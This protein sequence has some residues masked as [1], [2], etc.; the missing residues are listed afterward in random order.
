MWKM[1]SIFDS[2]C[3][4]T[5]NSINPRVSPWIGRNMIT[6]SLLGRWIIL[7]LLARHEPMPKLSV[8]RPSL[9]SRNTI[10]LIEQ[11]SSCLTSI[12]QQITN[13]LL[14]LSAG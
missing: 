8:I 12:S 14:V 10:K 11:R 5:T 3:C 4:F 9:S 1:M 13:L 6:R 2:F 7:H